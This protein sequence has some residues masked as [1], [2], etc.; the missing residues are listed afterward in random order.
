[1]QRSRMKRFLTIVLL[2]LV[3]ITISAS[4][5]LAATGDD[6]VTKTTNFTD[7]LT[8]K[9]FPAVGGVALILAVGLLAFGH[10]SGTK[11][12]GLALV[13]IGIGA[14]YKPIID[15]IKGFFGG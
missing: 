10:Q 8:G 1:M 12:T 15:A 2:T 6:L 11:R 7:F 13:A 4:L 14:C 5:V 9:M 3:L